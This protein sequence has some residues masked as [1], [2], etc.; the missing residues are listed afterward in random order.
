MF[1]FFTGYEIN[2]KGR[3]HQIKQTILNKDKQIFIHVFLHNYYYLSHVNISPTIWLSMFNLR[4][5]F[6]HQVKISDDIFYV[7]VNDRKSDRFENYWPL[8]KGV[9]YNSYLIVDEKIALL[10]T[11]ERAFIDEY[12]DNIKTIIGDREVDYLIINHM[13][14]DH[15]GAIRA[16]V[17]EFPNITFV[18]NKKTFPILKSFYQSFE[19]TIEVKDGESLN[20]GKHNLQFH[21]IPMVHWPE[22]MVTY[23]T[24]TQT[25][26]S[27]DAFGSFGALNGGVFDD[28]L[29]L[30][31]YEEEMMRYFTNIVGKY[32]PHTQKA[33]R[34]LDGLEIKT[35][36]ALHGPIWR[37]HIEMILDK[38]ERWSTYQSEKGVVIVYGTMYGN[39][40]KMADAIARQL[41]V[42]GIKNIRIYDASKTHPSYIISDIFKFKG[43]IVGSCA[44]NNE[45]FPTVETLVLK[46]KHMGIK[47]KCLGVFGSFTW[48]GGGVKNLMKFAEDIK[49]E[50]VGSPVE[51]KG[52]LKE[53][54][55]Q[56]CIDLANAMAD[57]LKEE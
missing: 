9:A 35:I 29:D 24:T 54:K 11:V 3:V 13:E 28:E 20:L 15:S 16:I 31:Y 10:D 40:E 36:A 7:G 48:N 34:K 51:E 37:S 38:Y 14:P 19:N 33:L 50:V 6:M 53:D 49:W 56:Q 5:L 57:R 4:L 55:F 8:D 23:E 47:K 21:T 30:S 18:G 2:R 26:F 52:S 44:Y 12:I 1:S 27:A 45:M 39:T 46:I 43:F 25:L 22:T 42:R 41:A 17:K 32:C